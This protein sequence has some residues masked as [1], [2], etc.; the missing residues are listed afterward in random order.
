LVTYDRQFLLLGAKRNAVLELAEVEAYGRDSYGN[1]DY[2]CIYGLRPSEW[3][4][5]GVRLLGRTAVECTRDDLA[6]RIGR[7]A[8]SVAVSWVS[9]ERPLLLDP[10]AGS[11]NTLYWLARHLSGAHCVGFELEPEVFALTEENFAA[12]GFSIDI[13]NVDYRSALSDLKPAAGQLVVAFVA[14]PWGNALD[15]VVGLDLR[16]TSPPV[17]EIAKSL[18]TH[19][20]ANPVLLAIQVHETVNRDSLSELAG[21]FDWSILKI[22]DLLPRGSNHGVLLATCRWRPPTEAEAAS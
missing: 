4:A 3:Y 20:A 21:A 7:D 13:R 22:Y 11:G 18:L 1:P 5:K 10:F 6:D 17:P 19:F 2:V 15:P 8:A 14:P 9:G 16:R 12:L